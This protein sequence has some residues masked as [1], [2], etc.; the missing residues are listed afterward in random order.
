MIQ[1][2]RPCSWGASDKPSPS[3]RKTKQGMTEMR[4]KIRKGNHHRMHA[5]MLWMCCPGLSITRW[6]PRRGVNT[7][8]L[9]K[10]DLRGTAL[11]NRAGCIKTNNSRCTPNNYKKI[12]GIICEKATKTKKN[13]RQLRRN[14][15]NMTNDINNKLCYYYCSLQWLLLLLLLLLLLVVLLLLLLNISTITQTTKQLKCFSMHACII[16]KKHDF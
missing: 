11:L 5:S 13:T 16:K 6:I 15:E 3:W 2:S 14:T 12:Y 9:P 1:G 10:G 8:T 4:C 7:E